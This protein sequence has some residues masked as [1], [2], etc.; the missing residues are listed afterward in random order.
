M[1]RKKISDKYKFLMDFLDDDDNFILMFY[2]YPIIL[3]E[4]FV[5]KDYLLRRYEY[6]IKIGKL[7]KP[8]KE[9]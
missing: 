2:C 4:S 7:E 9:K 3:L 5:P 8:K 6:L 1:K